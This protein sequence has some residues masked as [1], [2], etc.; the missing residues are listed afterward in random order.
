[1]L[2]CIEVDVSNELK[3]LLNE[4]FSYVSRKGIIGEFILYLFANFVFGACVFQM[5]SVE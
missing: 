3:I 1:M 4:S 5:Q 2:I